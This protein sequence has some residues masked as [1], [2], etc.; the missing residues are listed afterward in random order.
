LHRVATCP[1]FLP[2]LYILEIPGK[3]ISPGIK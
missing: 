3:K 1:T 2:L